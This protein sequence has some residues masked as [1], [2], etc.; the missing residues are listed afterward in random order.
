MAATPPLPPIEPSTVTRRL[1]ATCTQLLSE[2]LEPT[3]PDGDLVPTD[4]RLGH[5]PSRSIQAKAV[6]RSRREATRRR[7][8]TVYPRG[9]AGFALSV[10]S[11]EG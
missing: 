7:T 11:V 4:E 6:R 10:C 2:R 9:S 8:V 5:Q 3:Q 1:S